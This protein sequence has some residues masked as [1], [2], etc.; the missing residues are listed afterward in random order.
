MN[1]LLAILLGGLFGAALYYVG[2]SQ[3]KKL[4]GMLRFQDLG[5]MKIIFFAIGFASTLLAIS[6]MLGIFDPSHLS[7][8]TTHLGVLIG[9]LIFGI[10][11][12]SIGTCPG[13]CVVATT[14]GGF[15]KGIATVVGGLFGAFAFSLTY[16][17]F[18]N[19]GLFDTMNL[20]KLTWFNISDKFPS[21]FNIGYSGLFLVGI[22]F[23]LIAFVLPVH[24]FQKKNKALNK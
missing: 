19:M 5:L 18:K 2:A 7:I 24:P 21:V 8:K 10:G 3:S 14:S 6:S 4:L 12:G 17:M 20:G 23:M 1:I 15:K 13:T 16:G 9:G 11:F 22:L